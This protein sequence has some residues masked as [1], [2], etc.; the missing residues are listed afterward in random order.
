MAGKTAGRQGKRGRG[1]ERTA[2]LLAERIREAGEKRGF[3]VS[4]VLTHW[5]EV[6]GEEIADLSRPVKVSYAREGFGGTL[7]LL[8]AGA[9]AP[10]VQMRA[11]EIKTRV[12]G[13]YGYNAISH[14]R[15]TQ[16][17]AAGFAEPAA[18][19]AAAPAPRVCQSPEQVAEQVAA[20]LAPAGDIDDP[21]LRAALERLAAN[22]LAHRGRD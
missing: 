10:L 8:C 12:N 21:G 16:T 11:D 13:C 22:V 19:F 6:V 14:V 2:G 5:A 18:T 9:A 1:F 4:R 3:A 7:T 17:S 15:I 20:T